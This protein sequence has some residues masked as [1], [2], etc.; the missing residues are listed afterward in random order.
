EDI[1]S[2]GLLSDGVLQAYY[3]ESTKLKPS[4]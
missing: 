4:D 2:D 3:S 1:S